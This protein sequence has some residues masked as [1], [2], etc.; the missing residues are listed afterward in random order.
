MIKK[1]NFCLNQKIETSCWRRYV[2]FD[3]IVVGMN[4]LAFV[5]D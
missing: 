1:N 3:F 4:Y 2:A 5:L